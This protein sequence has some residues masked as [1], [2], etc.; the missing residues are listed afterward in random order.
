MK[1]REHFKNTSMISDLI[2]NLSHIQS[3]SIG[4][5]QT[6]RAINQADNKSQLTPRL[7]WSIKIRPLPRVSSHGHITPAD[8]SPTPTTAPVGISRELGLILKVGKGWNERTIPKYPI[9]WDLCD[10]FSQD[11]SLTSFFPQEIRVITDKIAEDADSGDI[12]ADWRF[13]ISNSCLHLKLNW[14]DSINFQICGD[15]ARP[16][17]PD[18]VHCL[19]DSSQ[20]GHPCLSTAHSCQIVANN[21]RKWLSSNICW[22]P[23]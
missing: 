16:N 2:I 22:R 12:E 18:S 8:E 19:H 13:D 17:L 9:T 6:I 14:F 10:C 11:F 21:F 20:R 15:G 1:L 23:T 3:Q 4:S 7:A 5:N